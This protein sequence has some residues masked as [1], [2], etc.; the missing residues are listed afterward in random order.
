MIKRVKISQADIQ[1]LASKT[2]PKA[3]EN[4][5]IDFSTYLVNKPWGHE[6]L[7]FRN[8]FVEVWGLHI[9]TGQS[10]SMH[11]HPNKKTGMLLIEGEAIFSNLNE[12]I[13]MKPLD[14]LIV[15]AGAFKKTKAVSAE[16]ILLLEFETPPAKHDLL[17]LTDEYGRENKPYEG[18][19]KMMIDE[20]MCVRFPDGDGVF[21]AKRNLGG[22]DF[23]IKKISS[24][25]LSQED[26]DYLRGHDLAVVLEGL[27]FWP[28]NDYIFN[29]ADVLHT[30]DILENYD[31]VRIFNL[32]LMGIKKQ[33]PTKFE[34]PSLWSKIIQKKQ[35]AN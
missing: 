5:V 25:A 19:D 21:D 29:V 33:Q 26:V 20:E 6:Y 30:K 9:K 17:R 3:P 10:T 4:Q 12:D 14:A 32:T 1:N 15:D 35:H 28:G 2:P 23:S 8:Q 13:A 27:V 31:S 24:E 18:L 11:C 34:N 16:G 7:M 22:C